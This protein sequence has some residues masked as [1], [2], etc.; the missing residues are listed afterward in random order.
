[1]P[2]W[3]PIETAPRDGSNILLRVDGVACEGSRS[4][5]PDGAIY[6]RTP[7]YMNWSNHSRRMTEFDADV[8][9]WAPLPE[10]LT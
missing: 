5:P 1:M 3:Q 10:P 7:S 8:T 4:G 6:S 9:H 2:H